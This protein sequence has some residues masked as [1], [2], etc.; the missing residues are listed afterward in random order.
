MNTILCDFPTLRTNILMLMHQYKITQ[1]TTNWNPP[2][3]QQSHECFHLQRNLSKPY[4]YLYLID[5]LPLTLIS[6]L[7]DLQEKDSNMN[8]AQMILSNSLF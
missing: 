1:T 4:N 8:G 5:S 3:K 6:C 7:M 2:P